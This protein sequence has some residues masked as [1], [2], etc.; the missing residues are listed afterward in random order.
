MGG[1]V[2]RARVTDRRR[3]HLNRPAPRAPVPEA[4]ARKPGKKVAEGSGP[5]RASPRE[6]GAS[7]IGRVLILDED[8]AAA[9]GMADALTTD[10]HAVELF[11]N[12][13]EGIA[14]VAKL[15]PDVVV[16]DP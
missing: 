6:L 4:F 2:M 1:M 14:A 9:S 16:V 8:S 5:H 11:P 10:G 15:A 13:D 3:P 12:L 7:V